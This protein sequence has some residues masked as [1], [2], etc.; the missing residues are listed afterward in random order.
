MRKNNRYF[1]VAIIFGVLRGVEYII[2]GQKVNLTTMLIDVGLKRPE[3]IPSQL[4]LLTI[5][6]FPVIVFQ[7]IFGVHIYSHYCVASVY[8]FSRQP[9]RIRW[10]MREACILL[11]ITAIY[12]LLYLSSIMGVVVITGYVYFDIYTWQTFIYISIYFI[13]FTF[14]VT[15]FI[16]ILSILLG[17]QNAFVVTYIIQLYFIF[18]LAL[19]DPYEHDYITSV[20]DFYSILPL[21]GIWEKLF[22]LNP[23]ANIVF[24]WH[25]AKGSL[26]EENI[27]MFDISFPLNFSIIYFLVLIILIVI[28]G[29]YVVQKVDISLDNKEL[30]A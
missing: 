6:M 3:L 25:S 17:S 21:E 1:V 15:L 14:A 8:Y 11:I 4:T 28:A 22:K 10:Y 18:S 30:M 19:Y 7:I 5:D 13:L 27:N 24:V 26:L 29:G 20:P 2:G 9:N 12:F 23:I 16:N